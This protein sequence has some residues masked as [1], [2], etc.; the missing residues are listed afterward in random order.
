M[1]KNTSRILILLISFFLKFTS[2]DAQIFNV[3]ILTGVNACKINGMTNAGFYKLGFQTGLFVWT[4]ISDVGF[5]RAE[6]K[7]SQKGNNSTPNNGTDP[8]ITLKYI[9]PS[10]IFGYDLPLDWTKLKPKKKPYITAGITSGYLIVSDEKNI[11]TQSPMV[12]TEPLNK[13]DIGYD[14]GLGLRLSDNLSIEIRKSGSILPIGNSSRKSYYITGNQYNSV[15]T[16][17]LIFAFGK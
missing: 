6:L 5:I 14:I 7:Y 10:F 9:E 2:V 1:T 11:Y 8:M 16:C 15:I 13:Y 12:K 3:G 17:I 4:S